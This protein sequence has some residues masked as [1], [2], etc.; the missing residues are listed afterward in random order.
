M[1]AFLTTM[2]I[3]VA[4]AVSRKGSATIESHLLDVAKNFASFGLFGKLVGGKIVPLEASDTAAVIH[5]LLVRAYPSGT[6]TIAATLGTSVPP[7][8]GFTDVLVRGYAIVKK[9]AGVPA[10]GGQVYVRIAN[11]LS[12]RPIGAI[13]TALVSGETVAVSRCLFTTAA[14]SDGF[15]EIEF[16]I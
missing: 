12:G 8:E 13:E 4:G 11:P 5:G 7:T 1:V 10:K 2:P 15:V 16:N 14:D 9:S 3:G 6:T